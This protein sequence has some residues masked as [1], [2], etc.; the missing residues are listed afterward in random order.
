MCQVTKQ[1]SAE[2]TGAVTTSYADPAAAWLALLL[3]LLKTLDNLNN[4]MNSTL[5]HKKVIIITLAN[6][7]IAANCVYCWKLLIRLRTGVSIFI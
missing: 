3:R 2:G 6:Y 7:L 4:G 1:L 5:T